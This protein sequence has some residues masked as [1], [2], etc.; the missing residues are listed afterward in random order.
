MTFGELSKQTD[1]CMSP[2]GKVSYLKE[3]LHM[4]HFKAAGTV[5]TCELQ[6][7]GNVGRPMARLA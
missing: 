5:K 3:V 7:D 6:I 4:M 1:V 2:Q